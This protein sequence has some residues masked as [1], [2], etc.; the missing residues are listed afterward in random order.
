MFTFL[1]TFIIGAEIIMFSVYLLVYFAD[2]KELKLRIAQKK[3]KIDK[4]VEKG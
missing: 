1:V 4:W 2:R 3:E